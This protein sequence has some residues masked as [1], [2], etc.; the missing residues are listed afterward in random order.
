M[1]EYIE[2]EALIKALKET[3]KNEQKASIEASMLKQSLYVCLHDKCAGFCAQVM[4]A[5]NEMPAADVVGTMCCKDCI[6]SIDIDGTLYCGEWEHNTDEDGYCHL[7][8]AVR[9]E[10]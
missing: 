10:K 9:G 3:Y 8:Y 7:G 6:N 4:N 5:V 2:R 1:K